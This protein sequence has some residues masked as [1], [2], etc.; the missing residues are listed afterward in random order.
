M[1]SDSSPST[2]SQPSPAP[3]FAAELRHRRRRSASR[4]AARLVQDVRDHRGRRALAVRPRD[5][6]R[7]AAA[8]RARQEVRP[9]ASPRTPW[10]AAETTASHPSGT[11]GSGADLDAHAAE[12]REVRRLD[13]VP[14][15]DLGAPRARE[16][17]VRRE[18]RAA[19]ADEPEPPAVERG[20]RDQL[21]R[22]SG[23]PRADIEWLKRF[24]GFLSGPHPPARRFNA[25]QKL[26]FWS[27]IFGGFA[28][29]ASGIALLFPNLTDIGGI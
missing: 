5:D 10:Y 21:L 23:R 15:A 16:L 14:A 19:D 8:R 26:I 20:K 7:V 13:A 27:V 18:A 1:R 24:G 3:A 4:V 17:R 12:R 11:T 29:T 6:D 9:R 25:G 22:R 28:L 2:T